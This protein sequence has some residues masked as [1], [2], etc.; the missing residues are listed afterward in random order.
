M[1]LIITTTQL[2]NLF[3]YRYN[4]NVLVKSVYSSLI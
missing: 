1:F 3:K 4:F 2:R